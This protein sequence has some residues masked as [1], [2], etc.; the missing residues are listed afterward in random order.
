MNIQLL[1][2]MV[3]TSSLFLLAGCQQQ[4]SQR[5]PTSRSAVPVHVMKVSES[6]MPALYDATG[7]VRAKTTSVLS[8][9]VM[10]TVT[11]VSVNAGDAVKAGQVL[12]VLDSKDMDAQFESAQAGQQGAQ[13][14]LAEAESAITSAKSNTELAQV[15]FQRM[16]TLY[17]QRSISNQEFDEAN[18]K[19]K[20][21]QA[22]YEMAVAKRAQAQSAIAQSNAALR[23]AGVNKGYARIVA[24]FAGTITQK[25]VEPGSL[26]VPG[27]PLLSIERTGWYRLEASVEESKLPF[28]HV[29]QKIDVDVDALGHAVTGTVSEVAPTL[30]PAT[31][32][33]IVKIDLQNNR[34]LRS[35]LFGRAHFR[36]GD[37]NALVIP[38][39]AV[40]RNGQLQSVM[41]A[42]SGVARLR[43]ITT[44]E[45]Q[46]SGMTV[47]SG[48]EPGDQLID[49][50]P[51]GLV[52]GSPV[53]VRQ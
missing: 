46:G 26:A 35:G 19:L 49:P 42:E 32:T 2:S 9:N 22:S 15:T 52:D 51:A 29:G 5:S 53:E 50:L 20:A 11:S 25:N 23:V 4:P 38:A 40:N 3:L 10:G 41:L 34:S 17:D 24:P 47:L 36:T 7:T 48:L 12:V 14:S 27:S 1:T 31:R 13:S 39:G 45:A 43:I 6:A 33:Y 37:A 44:G 21:A 16:K 8:S 28:I 18:A 30:D